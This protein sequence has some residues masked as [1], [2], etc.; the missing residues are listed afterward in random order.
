MEFSRFLLILQKGCYFSLVVLFFCFLNS[1]W[2][3]DFETIHEYSWLSYTI[4]TFI[5]CLIDVSLYPLII[6][7][8]M[9][10][11]FL[12]GDIRRFKQYVVF[13]C[14]SV[15]LSFLLFITIDSSILIS[16][17]MIILLMMNV[18]MFF[19]YISHALFFLR[20]R[21]RVH[22]KWKSAT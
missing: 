14:V 1:V 7:L 13:Y 11:L 18:L 4:A 19:V 5:F 17:R 3:E 2:P 8:I 15:C 10:K 12:V 22:F 9:I 20:K 6:V 16:L 21:K